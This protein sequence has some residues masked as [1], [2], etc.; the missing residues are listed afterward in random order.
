MNKKLIFL[1]VDGVLNSTTFY[2]KHQT[3]TDFLRNRLDFE[4]IVRLRKIVDKTGA[5]IVVSSTWRRLPEDMDLLSSTLLNFDLD[6]MDVTPFL[7]NKKRGDEISAW[8]ESHPEYKKAAYIILDDDSDMT[9]HM[10][11]LIKTNYACGLSDKET[12]EAIE[13]LNTG[14]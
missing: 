9:V 3:L 7:Y 14:E 4:A 8:F 6:I 11:H 10:D 5:E 2:M 13:R 12:K 1:D